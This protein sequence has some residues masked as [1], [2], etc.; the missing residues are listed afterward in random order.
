MNLGLESLKKNP[1]GL[2]GDGMG[3]FVRFFQVMTKQDIQEAGGKAANLGE[4]TQAGFTVPPGF[5]VTANS[6]SHH[7]KENDLQEKIEKIA[8]GFNYEDYGEIESKTS[9]IRSLITAVPIP[10]DLEKELKEAIQQLT[11]HDRHLVAVRSSV[12]VKGS[13]ISS[14]PGMM[15]TF[16]YLSGQEEIIGHI[17][18]CWASLWTSRATYNRFHKHID[19][20]LGLIAPIVQ[21]MINPEV[22]GILFT[23]NPITSARDEMVIESNWGL[24]ESVVSGKSMNDFFALDKATLTIKQKKIAKKTVMVCFNKEAGVGRKEM[25]V[26]PELMDI[27]TLSDDQVRGLGKTGL[28]IETLFGSPQDIEWAYAQE[29]QY[30]LQSRNIR[31]LKE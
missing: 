13:P 22:A 31:N 19:H 1:A 29:K 7:I 3:S 21:Q 28:Q 8:A 9:A 24:G 15:D 2:E 4:L 23:A 12:A 5:C 10:E 16:H 30:I 26:D 14:F 17:K 25:A 11:N 27:P 20:N 18:M 6:L